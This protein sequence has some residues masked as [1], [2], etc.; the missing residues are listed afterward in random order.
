M[1]AQKFSQAFGAGQAVKFPAGRYFYVN[2]APAPID[3]E[4]Y[5]NPGAPARFL[6]VSTG[7]KFGPVAEGQGWK[8]LN[9]TSANAQTVEITVS[10]DGQ[11]EV[12]SAVTVSGTVT[13]TQ[14]PGAT[15]T[16]QADVTNIDGTARQL[17]AAA[18]TRRRVHVKAL[19]LNGFNI[20]V[21]SAA[22]TAA[23]GIQLQ[24][25]EGITLETA[26][27]VFAIRESGGVSQG[28]SVLEE[29]T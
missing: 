4:T 16:P 21:G 5:G 11:F 17:A 15:L 26:A 28:A 2:S 24:P 6:Q 7:A 23:S 20:R 1:S 22:V 14:V 13:V 25:G 29:L 9:V 3:I 12:P 10:D 18:A 8:Y 27:A 19:G